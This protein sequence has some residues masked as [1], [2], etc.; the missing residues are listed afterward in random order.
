MLILK[1]RYSSTQKT[2]SD[3]LFFTVTPG[4]PDCHR[5]DGGE[6]V[7]LGS[8][9]AAFFLCQA[10][11]SGEKSQASHRPHPV[12]HRRGLDCRQQRLDA[13]DA[14]H[15]LGCT[16]YRKSELSQLVSGELQSSV[17]G[18]YSGVAASI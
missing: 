8:H 17:V 3:A 2:N 9:T 5:A 12:A 6:R 11:Y 10:A 1:I 7:V 18:G 15:H 13:A 4:G 16:G 14:T